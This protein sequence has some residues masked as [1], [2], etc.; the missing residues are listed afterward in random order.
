[1]HRMYTA[2]TSTRR[3]FLGAAASA[4]LW[5]PHAPRG[6]LAAPQEGG[7]AVND[8]HARLNAT[9]VARIVQPTS[10]A[11]L[12]AAVQRA[13]R[14]GRTVSIAG[15]RHAMGGQQFGRGTTL[16]D[17]T[18]MGGVLA[19]DAE[20]GIVEAEAG[21]Q[22]PE[23]M[24]WL[25]DAQHGVARPWGIVQKQTGAD[26]LSLGGALSANVHGRGLRL[27]PIIQDVDSIVVV[28]PDGA[29]QV[30]SRS[31]NAELFS[32]VIGGYGLFGPI[33]SVRL[34]LAP[35]RKL[36]RVVELRD[37]DGLAAAV[38]E[39]VDAGF[40]YGD[41]QF[42]T[43]ADDARF[44]RR[45]VFTC[46]RPVAPDTPIPPAQRRLSGEDW[47]GLA[48]LAHTDPARA[49]E[50]YSGYYLS[51]DGQI[52]RS[53]DHQMSYYDDGYHVALSRRLGQLH[54]A[55]EMI[56]EI[57]VPRPDLASFMDRA[58][59]TLRR[60]NAQLIYGTVRWIEQDPDSFLAW[61]RRPWACVIFNLHVDHTDAGLE[62]AGDAFRGLID[63]GLA[64]AGS[65]YLTY[66]RWARR[67]QVEAAHPRVIDFLSRKQ[68]H[69]PAEV[70]QSDWYRHYRDMFSG[71][72]GA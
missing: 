18:A 70:F 53:D 7:I 31:V 30:C 11:E 34:R 55:S 60:A 54:G 2:R 14:E 12:Q 44:L 68:R 47:G 45:G 63:A 21:I 56:T 33:S 49:F 26:R 23:L 40:E 57:Y 16:I 29:Q 43:G 48:Y 32:L 69:D 72:L 35:R 5:L 65:Y 42:A 71:E 62:R 61:A 1:M 10:A 24:G 52:Y 20:R 36:E 37:V 22:W 4:A 25:A 8:V 6:L 59:A 15:G 58:S 41:F 66:H 3:T 13:A 64:H 67:D 19:F 46:Y 39:R 38:E 50:Q 27:R 9:R 51:T 28:D 17:T